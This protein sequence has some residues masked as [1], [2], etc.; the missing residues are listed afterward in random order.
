DRL[1]IQPPAALSAGSPLNLMVTGRALERL[2]EQH[3]QRVAELRAKLDEA[4]QPP[5]LEV[6]GGVVCRTADALL[7][8]AAALRYIPA[9]RRRGGA[10]GT[11]AADV[12]GVGPK[13]SAHP[14][15]HPRLGAGARAAPGATRVIGRGGHAELPGHGCQLDVPGRQG[16]RRLHSRPRAGSQG[17]DV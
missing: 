3:P 6:I 12:A 1:D 10:D 17:R 16:D 2:K 13:P 8:V 4:I 9:A 7:S 14:P 5:V 11:L 15:A